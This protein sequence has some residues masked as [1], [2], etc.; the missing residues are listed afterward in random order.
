MRIDWLINVADKQK[1]IIN[2]KQPIQ[3]SEYD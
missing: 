3:G 2:L 1:D